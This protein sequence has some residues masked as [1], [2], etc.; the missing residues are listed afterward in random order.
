MGVDDDHDETA[1]GKRKPSPTD[2]LDLAKGI[3]VVLVIA[4][5]VYACSRT[6]DDKQASKGGPTGSSDTTTTTTSRP[7]E[8][9]PGNGTYNMGGVDGKDWGVWGSD[10]TPSVC[11]WSIV[12]NS[13][14]SP[15]SILDHGRVEPGEAA[16]VNIQPLGDTS[17]ITG[18][19]HGVRLKFITNGCGS[20]RLMD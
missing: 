16:Q 19:S 13:A 12:A 8:T 6:E 7:Y 15:A 4:V 14:Y 18:E 1:A 5:V 17:S 2:W 9:M 20:W 11:I 10:A 3:V